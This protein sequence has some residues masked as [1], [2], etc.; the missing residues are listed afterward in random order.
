MRERDL[1]INGGAIQLRVI[2]VSQFLAPIRRQ[3]GV[4]HLLSYPRSNQKRNAQ[5]FISSGTQNVKNVSDMRVDSSL[6]K[7]MEKSA[8]QQ[9][10]IPHFGKSG[11]PYFGAKLACCRPGTKYY[12]DLFFFS[13]EH[14]G[15]LPPEVIFTSVSSDPTFYHGLCFFASVDAFLFA[16]TPPTLVSITCQQ[17]VHCQGCWWLCWWQH[18]RWQRQLSSGRMVFLQRC[19]RW[20][21]P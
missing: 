3:T 9:A 2:M 14:F 18:W 7:K 6:Q 17:S 13:S 11:T 8:N 5:V 12:V 4:S 21:R 1:R 19:Q 15:T 16:V 10:H 20:V